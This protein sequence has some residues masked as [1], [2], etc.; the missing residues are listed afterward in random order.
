MDIDCLCSL[1]FFEDIYHVM[2]INEVKKICNA[3]FQK[4]QNSSPSILNLFLGRMALV[5]WLDGNGH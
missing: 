1:L 2:A 3:K 4:A 5:V